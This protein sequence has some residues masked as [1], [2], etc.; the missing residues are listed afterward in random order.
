LRKVTPL[1][2]RRSRSFQTV[3]NQR[4]FPTSLDGQTQQQVAAGCDQSFGFERRDGRVE[5]AL[6]EFSAALRCIVPRSVNQISLS[7]G[8]QVRSLQRC[9][10]SACLFN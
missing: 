6:C 1:P 2:C 9:L 3:K 7:L 5:Y 8:A 10:P 4:A